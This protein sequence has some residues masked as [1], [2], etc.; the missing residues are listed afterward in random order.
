[1]KKTGTYLKEVHLLQLTACKHGSIKISY[2]VDSGASI[3]HVFV[4]YL[5]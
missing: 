1:M 5:E 2:G 3:H 4:Q